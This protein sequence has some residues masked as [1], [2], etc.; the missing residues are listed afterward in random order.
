MRNRT[1][2]GEGAALIFGA[3]GG[4]GSAIARGFAEAGGNVA[5]AYRSNCAA[6]DG[7][8]DE[9][10]SGGHEAEAFQA[11]VTDRAAVGRAVA[12]AVARFGR[13]HSVVFVAGP[14]P[15]QSYVADFTP[16]EW[17]AAVDTELHGFFNVVQAALPHLRSG[18]G[19]SFVHLGSAGDLLWPARDGLSV[20]PKAANEALVRGIAREEGRHGIR[21]NSVLIGVIE[22]GMFLKFEAQGVFDKNW[23]QAV[24]AA[25]PL[26]RFGTGS[27]V[28]DAVV[29]FASSRAAYVTG[30]RIAVAGGYGI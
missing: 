10:R 19:G 24:K 25:L 8:L 3:S 4:I 11:D 20:A 13:V 14:M 21:A 7:L 30:Q 2:F 29:F 28:A 9:L 16:E 27:E 17:R 5:A 15:T 18:G 22:A 26:G 23:S 6:V 12:A 1:D